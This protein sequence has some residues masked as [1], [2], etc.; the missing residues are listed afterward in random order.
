MPDKNWERPE[1]KVVTEMF[2]GDER[3]V[4][5]MIAIIVGITLVFSVAAVLA[6]Q[7]TSTPQPAQPFDG[8]LVCKDYDATKELG[9]LVDPRVGTDTLVISHAGGTP[10]MNAYDVDMSGDI[11]WR[12]LIA[13][14]NGGYI[15][16]FDMGTTNGE[17][18]SPILGARTGVDLLPGDKM[19]VPLTDILAMA[20][21]GLIPTP[22][23][24][25]DAGD[26]I[27]L[28][29]APQNQVIHRWI[30]PQS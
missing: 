3:G 6:T 5:T 9:T 23:S 20:D 4:F 29:Y 14:V 1:R 21:N 15:K 8:I 27:E 19:I 2:G 10:L 17:A 11:T 30:V 28:I 13:K 18:F 26:A 7:L 16:N 24:T 22:D 12:N 25:L